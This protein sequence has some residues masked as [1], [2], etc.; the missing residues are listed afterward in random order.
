MKVNF[1]A[2][3]KTKNFVPQHEYHTTLS[4][5]PRGHQN[6]VYYMLQSQP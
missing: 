1:E 4:K 6:Q 5:S 3:F 2:G